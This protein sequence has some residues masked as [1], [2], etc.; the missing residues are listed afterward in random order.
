MTDRQVINSMYYCGRMENDSRISVFTGNAY[1][2]AEYSPRSGETRWQRV[3]NAA[4]KQ[5]IHDW[6][7][8]HYPPQ[9]IVEEK[10]KPAKTVAAAVVV[11]P[12]KTAKKAAAVAR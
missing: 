3:V 2:V 7:L 4:Q 1:L 9:Q 10:K 6:L 12:V 8:S 11:A 5:G